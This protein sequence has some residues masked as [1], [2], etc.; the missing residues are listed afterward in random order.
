M[1]EDLSHL[2]DV[3][4]DESLEGQKVTD[5]AIE[6]SR[7]DTEKSNE[8]VSKM[9]P[10]A[11]DPKAIAEAQAKLHREIEKGEEQW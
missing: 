8:Q 10:Q 7:H 11:T 1:T 4:W 3:R 5:D 9:T 2:G 6:A